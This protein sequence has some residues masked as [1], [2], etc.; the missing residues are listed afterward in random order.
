MSTDSAS[1][2]HETT[3]PISQQYIQQLL[4]ENKDIPIQIRNINTVSTSNENT[5]KPAILQKYI[6]ATLIK[7]ETLSDLSTMTETLT[8]RLLQSNLIKNLQPSFNTCNNENKL[9]L[10]ISS[11]LYFQPTPKFTARTGTNIT[12]SG[13]GDAYISFQKRNLF[14]LEE[15][16]TLDYRRDTGTNSGSN[17]SVVLP[18]GINGDPFW[19]S[20][21]DIFDVWKNVGVKDLGLYMGTKSWFDAKNTWNYDLGLE[22]VKRNFNHKLNSSKVVSDYLLI[23]EGEFYKTTLRSTMVWDGRN[24][25]TAPTKGRLFKINNDLGFGTNNLQF[26]RHVTEF[27]LVK[28]WLKDDFITMSN[29]IKFG[30]IKNL[31]Q[32][33]IHFTDK[34]Q[35][36]GPNDI[37]SFQSMG[38]GPRHNSYSLGGDA[39]LS[40]GVSIFSKLPIQKFHDS[41]FRL[42]WFFNGGKLINHDNASIWNCM[43]NLTIENSTSAGVGVVLRHPMARFEMNF[44]VPITDHQDDLTRK[45]FQFGLGFEFL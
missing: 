13:Q 37:R 26:W 28:S 4:E 8:T 9:P 19:S 1:R 23:Q 2:N 6:D 7:A 11:T 25:K 36:G 12:N 41:N 22:M 10:S 14:G 17:L 43:Q 15:T 39:F 3:T 32:D 40:Y 24:G 33:Y 21:L 18:Y 16:T 30:Y 27:N 35:N 20:K 42:H 45:G 38:I 31:S 44:A 34:F 5:I 29:T